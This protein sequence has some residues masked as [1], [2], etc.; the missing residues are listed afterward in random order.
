MKWISDPP[1]K[2]EL[3]NEK[4]ISEWFVEKLIVCSDEFKD[5]KIKLDATLRMLK[6]VYKEIIFVSGDEVSAAI[7][8]RTTLEIIFSWNLGFR[9][10]YEHFRDP[11]SQSFMEKDPEIYLQE[12]TLKLLPQFLQTES[13]FKQYS[14]MLDG[15]HKEL[16]EAIFEYQSFVDTVIPKL[17]H[18]LGF[19]YADK[20]L[21]YI[22]PDYVQDRSL[23]KKYRNFLKDI[24]SIYDLFLSVL[25][26]G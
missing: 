26:S 11:D 24:D 19:R 16:F 12:S 23:T 9:A 7:E 17:A 8:K 13:V 6:A 25:T 10:N 1:Q 15:Y 18:V 5:A 4:A 22:V 20:I 2:L 14:D 21:P 3:L